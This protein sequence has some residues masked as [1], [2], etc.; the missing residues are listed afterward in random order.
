[1]FCVI[2]TAIGTKKE[3]KDLTQKLFE[4]GFIACAK[5]SKVESSYVWEGKF[6]QHKEYVLDFITT[7]KQLKAVQKAILAQHSYKL[8]EIIAFKPSY[9]SESYGK[10][11]KKCVKEL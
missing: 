3:A 4:K 8:P 7:Q 5:M 10:W 1:M 2:Q 11:A 9:L 6:C